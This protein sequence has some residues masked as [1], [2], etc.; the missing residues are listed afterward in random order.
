MSICDII[1]TEIPM[2]LI[3]K[4]GR[5]NEVFGKGYRT[6]HWKGS[7]RHIH[8]SNCSLCNFTHC[9]YVQ[10]PCSRTVCTIHSLL[11]NF[12]LT[13]GRYIQ[14]RKKIHG[15]DEEGIVPSEKPYCE[16][17]WK[18]IVPISPVHPCSVRIFP[19]S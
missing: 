5:K 6:D 18:P 16:D 11:W 4:G 1:K 3:D 12:P 9:V 10:K 7:E 2:G 14:R 15:K 13:Q 8:R 17:G 19:T